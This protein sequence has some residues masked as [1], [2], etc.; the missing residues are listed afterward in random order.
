MRKRLWSTLPS[1][2]DMISH[3][4]DILPI[5]NKMKSSPP[6]ALVICSFQ[7]NNSTPKEGGLYQLVIWCTGL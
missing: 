7:I 4:N 3:S 1:L 2:Y 6:T 5:D